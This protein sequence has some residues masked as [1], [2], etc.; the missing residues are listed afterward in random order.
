MAEANV[1]A[2]GLFGWGVE[3]SVDKFGL[4]LLTL[5]GAGIAAHAVAS[6][7]AHHSTRTAH[8]PVVPAEPP[9]GKTPP[10]QSASAEAARAQPPPA[11]PTPED[12]EKP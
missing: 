6:G 4:G 10:A 11:A 12:G 7:V 9:P 2:P 5:A 1:N 8:P 3:N